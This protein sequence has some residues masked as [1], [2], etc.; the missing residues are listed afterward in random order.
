MTRVRKGDRVR[1]HSGALKDFIG[2]VEI[3]AGEDD[4]VTDPMLEGFAYVRIPG[5]IP[6]TWW[7]HEDELELV[8]SAERKQI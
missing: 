8:A 2:S 4:E 5:K 1:V 7:I 3:E 6:E